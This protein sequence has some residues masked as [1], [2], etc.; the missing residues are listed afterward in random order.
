LIHKDLRLTHL[1]DQIELG[2]KIRSRKSQLTLLSNPDKKD[3]LQER[4]ENVKRIR[5]EKQ[6]SQHKVAQH[7]QQAREKNRKIRLD[8]QE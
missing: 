5:V 8:T 1:Q 4:R 7:K 6:E 2:K 3:V